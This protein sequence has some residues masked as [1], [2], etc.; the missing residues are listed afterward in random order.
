MLLLVLFFTQCNFYQIHGFKFASVTTAPG[1]QLR[2]YA[3]NPRLDPYDIGIREE[4]L[5]ASEKERLAFIQKLTNE[6]DAFA[7]EAGFDVDKEVS[8]E[9]IEISDTQ[10]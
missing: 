2:L 7:R 3:R 4:N 10:W 6:A 5:S 8:P 9:Q 1:V